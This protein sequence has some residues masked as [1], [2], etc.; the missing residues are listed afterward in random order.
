[1]ASVFGG[2]G[3]NSV[4]RLARGASR[5]WRWCTTYG[6]MLAAVVI[7]SRLGAIAPSAR[8]SA[9]CAASWRQRP[10]RAVATSGPAHRG[11][12]E[13]TQRTRPNEGVRGVDGRRDRGP[14][15]PMDAPFPASWVDRLEHGLTARPLPTW[16]IYALAWLVVWALVTGPALLRG[17]RIPLSKAISSLVTEREVIRKRPTWLVP[18]GPRGLD[19]GCPGADCGL[20]PAAA[21][22]VPCVALMPRFS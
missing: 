16:S 15:V 5:C 13:E 14:A 22:G 10:V 19:D 18:W 20:A 1:V 7:D 4:G 17:T 9:E 11:P 8:R 3:W 2:R 12:Q 21:A 6:I